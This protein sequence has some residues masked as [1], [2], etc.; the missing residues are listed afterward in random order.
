MVFAIRVMLTRLVP[1]ENAAMAHR[2]Q[3]IE[4]DKDADALGILKAGVS[5]PRHA[6]RDAARSISSSGAVHVPTLSRPANRA[7][8]A[9]DRCANSASR[10]TAEDPAAYDMICRADTMGVFQIESP[11]ADEHV[12]APASVPLYDIW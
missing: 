7:T 6:E 5:A 1:V 11:R 4:W 2:L 8:R 12:A 10:H 9:A 3:C